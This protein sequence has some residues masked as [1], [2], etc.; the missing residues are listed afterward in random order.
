MSSQTTVRKLA[1]LVNVPVLRLM[2]QLADAGLIFS[3]P[4]KP[5]SQ[6]EK[7]QLLGYLRR[8]SSASNAVKQPLKKA[9]QIT[10]GLEDRG[11]GVE[12]EREDEDLQIQN[13]FDPEK[14][15]V[16]TVT[17]TIDLL[18]RRIKHDEID[19]APEFQRRARIWEESRRSRLIESILLRIPLPV[20]YVASD[21]EENWA[22]VDGLQ[23]LT[24]ISDFLS[25]G[26]RLSG[27]EYLYKLNGLEFQHLPRQM[28]RRIEETELVMHVIEYGTPDS[29]MI[30]IFK[31]INTGGLSLNG[32]EIRN[33]LN[34]GE[35]RAFLKVLAESEEFELATGGSVGDNRME[36]QECALR[37]CAFF[38]FGWD[39]YNQSDLDG[40]LHQAMIHLN[41]IGRA[42]L[43]EL[44]AQFRWSLHIAH[45]IFGEHAFRKLY[46]YP[47]ERKNPVSKALF[48]AWSVNLAKLTRRDAQTL[49]SR[50]SAVM[51]AFAKTL[52]T[53]GGFEKS[54]SS[55][56]GAPQR[57]RTRFSVVEGILREVLA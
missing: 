24:T 27:L 9:K 45:S 5:I 44:D 19:L 48:E 55:S 33:A 50:R 31:R 49:V 36:A 21:A 29:V 46:E 39:D 38:E 51:D 20:F 32:Q 47:P 23:R 41:E 17:K 37:F 12:V 8:T 52:A 43:K 1:E 53:D 11:L 14:I 7:V 40:F 6:T 2:A 30:N 13:P 57:V 34:R 15:K 10:G 16:K 18:M 26:F 4:D 25:D 54:I 28:R 56:T 22:V 42:R 35:S 3:D